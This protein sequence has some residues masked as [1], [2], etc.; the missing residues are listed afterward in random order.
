MFLH[1]DPLA[2]YFDEI[3]VIL[4]RKDATKNSGKSRT[5]I[6]QAFAL[7]TVSI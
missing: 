6:S 4:I 5:N 3:F 1:Y 7:A 2:F